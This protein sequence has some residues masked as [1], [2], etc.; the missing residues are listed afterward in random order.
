MKQFNRPLTDIYASRISLF[1]QDGTEWADIHRAL[2][3]MD[4]RV[5]DMPKPVR[6]AVHH[7]AEV[8]REAYRAELEAADREA[9]ADVF[10]DM[11]L[12]RLYLRGYC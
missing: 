1:T 10:A 5:A 8:A 12:V 2:S 6:E 4:E 3:R 11:E 9:R 7:A